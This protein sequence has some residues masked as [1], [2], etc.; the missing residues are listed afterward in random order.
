MLDGYLTLG[1]RKFEIRYVEADCGFA[2]AASAALS[3]ALPFVADYFRLS[4]PLPKLRVV[5]VP[6][7]NEYD[8]IVCDLLRVQIEVPSSPS[9]I[10]QSQ[11][12][13]MVLLSPSAYESDSIYKYVP[14]EF[15]RLVVHELIHMVEEHLSP[16][17]EV[18]PRWWSEGLAVY[19]SEQ[20][21]HEDEFRGPALRGIRENEIPRISQVQAD[22]RLSYEWGWTLVRFL[23]STY[24]EEMISRIVKECT[25]GD[26]FS[27]TGEEEGI[28]E[29]CWMD[30]VLAGGLEA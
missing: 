7:R 26:V 21:R 27:I 15:R 14:D 17:I 25:D 6:N 28:L 22:R 1:D 18:T 8:R 13:D 24:G 3:K 10:G 12:T 20:W 30:W 16:D 11:R 29:K 9:R 5:L 23:E 2:D 4:E 19:L